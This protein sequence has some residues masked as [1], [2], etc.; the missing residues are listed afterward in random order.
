MK[1]LI[2]NTI[3]PR[4]VPWC[5]RSAHVPSKSAL[6][7]KSI[8]ENTL[9]TSMVR[10]S[11]SRCSALRC[12]VGQDILVNVGVHV[13]STNEHPWSASTLQANIALRLTQVVLVVVRGMFLGGICCIADDTAEEHD[14][15]RD[16][17][18]QDGELLLRR[19]RGVF[20]CGCP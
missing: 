6:S 13:H 19:R 14:Q 2:T 17:N 12:Q 18:C 3:Q 7:D 4:S 9:T 11:A 15:H 1:G 5:T 8:P 16:D 20:G 10:T